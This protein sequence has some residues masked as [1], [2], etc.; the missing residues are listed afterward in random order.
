MITSDFLASGGDGIFAGLTSLQLDGGG[1]ELQRDVVAHVLP[2][3]GPTLRADDSRWWNPAR[4]R[5][6]DCL[7]LACRCGP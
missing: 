6:C 4:S 7:R 3:F 2:T 1:D 5:G